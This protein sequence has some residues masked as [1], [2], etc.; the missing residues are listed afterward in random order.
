MS[1]KSVPIARCM[2]ILTVLHVYIISEYL[3]M[4]HLFLCHI[5]ISA[6]YTSKQRNNRY[7]LQAAYIFVTRVRNVNEFTKTMVIILFERYLREATHVMR[8]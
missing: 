5:I 2:Y 8:K 6:L 3:N 7:A 1:G 4:T